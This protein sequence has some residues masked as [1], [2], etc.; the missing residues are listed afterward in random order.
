MAVGGYGISFLETEYPADYFINYNS[1][2][3]DFLD[4]YNTYFP[5]S[6]EFDGYVY[7]GNKV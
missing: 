6:G 5:G 3:S 4:V 7:I 2:V 1:Y